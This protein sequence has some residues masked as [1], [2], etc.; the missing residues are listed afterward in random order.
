[1]PHNSPAL[2]LA[3]SITITFFFQKNNEQ[4]ATVTQHQ[5][6]DI[7]L[8]SIT[9]WA[10]IVKHIL[11]YNGTGPTTPVC[12]IKGPNGVLSQLS[13]KQL[14]NRLRASVK[15]VREDELGFKALELGTHSIRLGAAMAMYLAGVPVFTIILIGQWS[16]DAFLHYIRCQVQDFSSGVS[17]RM[18]VSQDFFTIPDL[19]H[20]EDPP[21]SENSH[22]FAVRSNIGPNAQHRATLPRMSLH[23]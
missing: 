11:S 8:C 15:T 21:V 1:V 12:T 20:H 19:A 22:N 18:I 5:T 3:D 14:L 7:E 9:A 10:G 16:S 6:L 17:S 2:H 23:H 4:D 13:S